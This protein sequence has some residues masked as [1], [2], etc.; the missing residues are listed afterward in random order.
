L[1]SRGIA[2]A[3]VSGW[4]R[5]DPTP[6]KTV[7]IICEAGAGKPLMKLVGERLSSIRGGRT[8]YQELSFAVEA[9]EAL[10]VLGPNG[11]GKTT[12]LR[13]VAGLLPPA[14]GQV[15]LADGQAGDAVAASSHYVGHLNALKARL[16][17]QENATFWA[18][19]LGDGDARPQAAVA[20]ALAAFGLAELRDV[21]VGYLSAGQRRRLGLARV[22][23]AQR[24]IWLLDEPAASLDEAA[25]GLLAR[26]IN[27][28]LAGG[29][30]VLA[31]T[32]QPLG[33]ARHRELHLGMAAQAA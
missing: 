19:F 22:L 2:C 4:S 26:T 23:L 24:P 9:G 20:S 11:V 15:R 7:L 12:L 28:H 27:A 10:L 17:V 30:L 21:P 8:L 5:H 25:Q 32:H 3:R 1:P 33:L 29:G 6:Y 18:Q 14:G 13:T 31:A 16:T